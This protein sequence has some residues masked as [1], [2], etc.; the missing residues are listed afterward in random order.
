M[1]AGVDQGGDGEP[2]AGGL[3]REGDARRGCAVVQEGFVG[4]KSVV[5][6]RRVRMLG[7]EPVVDGDDL[8]A[9]PP[10]DLRGQVSGEEGVPQYVDAAME[11]QDNMARF[12]SVDC[13]LGSWDAAQCGCGHGHIGRQRLRR[14][15]LS[16]QSPLL[17]YVVADGEG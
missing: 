6:R 17:A 5:D 12:D 10:A 11:V 16:E 14:C 8:G 3:S 9:R 4:C 13:D 15:Q 1:I 7:G 2:A